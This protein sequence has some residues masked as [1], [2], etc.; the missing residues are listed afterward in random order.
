MAPISVSRDPKTNQVVVTHPEL[1]NPIELGKNY[2][3][4]TARALDAFAQENK[5]H[6]EKAQRIIPCFWARSYNSNTT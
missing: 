4:G 3:S 5:N 6:K 1:S 2:P